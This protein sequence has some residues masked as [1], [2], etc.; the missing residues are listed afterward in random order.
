M[1]AL[2]DG[3]VLLDVLQNKEPF[4]HSSTLIL[5]LC[6]VHQIEGI[7]SAL[8]FV[9]VVCIMRREL[10]PS[11]MKKYLDMMKLIFTFADLETEYLYSASMLNWVNYEDSIQ[12]IIATKLQAEYIVTSNEQNF[13]LSVIPVIS[14]S[15]F[16]MKIYPQYS[17]II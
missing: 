5:K 9:N 8:S 15:N 7:V 17:E 13:E 10:L 12:Y 2:I 14:P 6:E 1:R 3:S 16:L 4:V 11:K